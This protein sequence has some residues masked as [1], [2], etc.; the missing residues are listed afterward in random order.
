MLSSLFPVSVRT[1]LL[2]RVAREMHPFL[3]VNGDFAFE[4]STPTRPGWPVMNAWRSSDNVVVET[5]IPGYRREDIE[6]LATR[7]TLT[8]QGRRESGSPEIG[9]TIHRERV[10]T[11]FARSITLPAPID[12]EAV[13]AQLI[14]GILT[15][16]LP[17]AEEARPR[18]VQVR[19]EPA[20]QN[21][22][23]DNAP[24][25]PSGKPALAAKPSQ[26]AGK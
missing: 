3:P 7:D 1:P 22:A 21:P 6:V 2:G 5:E 25:S 19:V 12:P 20:G 23:L 24:R 26:S 9:R 14:N 8:V 15:V 16:T 18:R 13:Q 17:L 4:A 11:E 10:A